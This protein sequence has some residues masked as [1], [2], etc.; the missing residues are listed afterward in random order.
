MS[1][2]PKIR[3]AILTLL[4]MSLSQLSQAHDEP[5]IEAVTSDGR[6]VYLLEDHT[7]DFIN[8]QSRSPENSAY[9]TITELKEMQDACAMQVKLE[10]NLGFKIRSLVPRFSIYND[11]N[12]VFDHKSLSFSSIKP[13][14][15]QYRSFQFNDIGCHEIRWMRVHGADHCTMGDLVDMFNEEEGQC[16]EFINVAPSDLINVSKDPTL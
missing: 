1:V 15:T 5:R 10:N 13:G 14:R 12:I 6:L 4:A 9:L 7:W 8:N 3:C 11:K 2:L 16:L